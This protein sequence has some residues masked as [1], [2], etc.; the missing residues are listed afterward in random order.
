MS[1][2]TIVTV[3]RTSPLGA[4]AVS[5]AAHSRQNFARSGFS[6]P[7]RSQITDRVYAALR[8]AHQTAPM[9][10]PRQ[11]LTDLDLVEQHVELGPWELSLLRP[12]QADALIDEDAFDHEEFLPYWA[13]L[14]A[15]GVALAEE[16]V[17]RDVHGLHVLELGCGLGV[18]SLAASL[19]GADVLATDWSP[20]AIALLEENA[21]RNDVPLETAIAAWANAD[22]L[23]ARAPWD[24]VLAADVLYERRNLDELL[25]LLPRLGTHVLL[26]DPGRPHAKTFFDCAAEAWA[27]EQRGPV[28]ALSA[29]RGSGGFPSR[30]G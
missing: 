15:S 23:V 17:A 13:E 30:G 6:V 20:T 7:Q 28:Y 5:G 21:R 16:A 18:P 25:E 2:K 19:A 8:R 24:L 26:A 27:I 10:P 14:W 22:A 1:Q 29:A 12:R 9:S 3:L 11:L 4:G